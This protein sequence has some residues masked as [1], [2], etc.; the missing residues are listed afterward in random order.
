MGNCHFNSEKI[1]QVVEIF[2]RKLM[3]KCGHEM[4]NSH[5]IISYNNKIMNIDKNTNVSL[6]PRWTKKNEPGL[7]LMKPSTHRLFQFVN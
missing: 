3:L 6:G 4:I 2:I 5:S 1:L 7:L